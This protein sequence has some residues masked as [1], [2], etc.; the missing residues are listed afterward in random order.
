MAEMRSLLSDVTRNEAQEENFPFCESDYPCRR[1]NFREVCPRAT[2][3]A[4]VHTDGAGGPP[5]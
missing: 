5:P 2:R 1:C 4:I 3:T